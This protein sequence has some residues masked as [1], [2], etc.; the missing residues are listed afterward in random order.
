MQKQN[1]VVDAFKGT[2]KGLVSTI[3][4]GSILVSIAEEIQNGIFQ[5]RFDEWKKNVEERLEN[6][7]DEVL[8]KLPH[9]DI[10]ATVLLISAQLALK[11][12][13]EKTKLLANAVANSSTT[14]LSEERVVILLNCIEKYT[15]S[16]LKLLRFL[17][18]PKEYNPKDNISMGSPMK[19][20]NDYYTKRDKSLDNVVIRDL[21]ADGLINTD[22]LNS[23][24]S[25]NGML[26]KRTTAL[27]DD[28]IQFFGITKFE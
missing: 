3:P 20:F 15:L 16:H 11:T 19:I 9:N 28:M 8:N 26:E 2:V 23:I 7:E 24:V 5:N 1:I 14:K 21:Y 22:S 12:N 18:N 6:L 13:Q 10:F 4:G 17:H 27:G 25:R